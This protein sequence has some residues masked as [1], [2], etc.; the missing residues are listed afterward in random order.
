MG[1]QRSEKHV[2]TVAVKLRSRFSGSEIKI[3]CM[4]VKE[5]MQG[6]LPKVV[7]PKEF[8]QIADKKEEGFPEEIDVLVGANWLHLVYAGMYK[9]VGAITSSPTKFG[10]VFWGDRSKTQIK[11]SVFTSLACVR[12]IAR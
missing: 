7:A 1:Q 9:R 5:V 6:T 4:A 11:S 8:D 10:W 12:I 2:E 3:A